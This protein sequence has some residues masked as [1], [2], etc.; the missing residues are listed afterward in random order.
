MPSLSLF[1]CFKNHFSLLFWG[2]PLPFSVLPAHAHTQ[3]SNIMDSLAASGVA[4]A[5]EL[6]EVVTGALVGILSPVVEELDQS[7]RATRSSQAK[8]ADEIAQLETAL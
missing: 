1:L 4:E 6:R 8:L 5:P 3:N 2:F 7:V